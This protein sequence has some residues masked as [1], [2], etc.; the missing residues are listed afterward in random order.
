MSAASAPDVASARAAPAI[1]LRIVMKRG[2]VL[3]SNGTGVY[4]G[5]EGRGD[6]LDSLKARA[7]LR[8]RLRVRQTAIKRKASKQA[9]AK[10]SD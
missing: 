2:H 9:Q 10:M 7:Q 6:P 5:G 4:N 3:D 8:R 1:K